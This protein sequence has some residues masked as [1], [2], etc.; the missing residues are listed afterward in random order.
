MLF[1]PAPVYSEFPPARPLA[2]NAEHMKSQQFSLLS[3][4]GLL[5]AEWHAVSS[6][7]HRLLEVKELWLE[8]LQG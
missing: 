4:S 7:F 5:G 8:T 3:A 6:I 2:Y 1:F